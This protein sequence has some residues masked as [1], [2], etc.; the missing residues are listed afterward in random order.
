M[1]FWLKPRHSNSFA[2]GQ[3][4]IGRAALMADDLERF[5][6]EELRHLRTLVLSFKEQ[7]TEISHDILEG[8]ANLDAARESYRC[9][10]A[11]LGPLLPHDRPLL[12]SD[13][14]T[15]CAAQV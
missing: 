2:L 9:C 15:R 12:P 7:V 14:C 3:K 6:P 13:P 1:P 8:Q 4:Q 10:S 5:G 11:S